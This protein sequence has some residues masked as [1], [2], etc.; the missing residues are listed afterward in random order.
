M[1]ERLFLTLAVLIALLGLTFHFSEP[2]EKVEQRGRQ[3]AIDE[4]Y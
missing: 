2:V 4:L 1:A 3:A